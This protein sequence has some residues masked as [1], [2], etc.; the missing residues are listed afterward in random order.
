MGL[1]IDNQ[2]A[3][4]E[5]NVTMSLGRKRTSDVHERVRDKAAEQVIS[6]KD[7]PDETIIPQFWKLLERFVVKNKEEK[8]LIKLFLE[9]ERVEQRNRDSCT[10]HL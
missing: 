9:K 4:E 6:F 8:E 1:S 2:D 3:E 5:P 7:V 10:L